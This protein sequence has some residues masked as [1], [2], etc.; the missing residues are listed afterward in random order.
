[1]SALVGLIMTGV[2]TLAGVVLTQCVH[3]ELPITPPWAVQI[4][5]DNV[6]PI[7]IG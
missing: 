3:G 6:P 1:M 7:G 4:A 5:S 2:F